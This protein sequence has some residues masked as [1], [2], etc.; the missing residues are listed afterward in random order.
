MNSTLGMVGGGFVGSYLALTYIAKD[1][2]IKIWI[3]STASFFNIKFFCR[4]IS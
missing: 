1:F 2:D 3:L 4:R